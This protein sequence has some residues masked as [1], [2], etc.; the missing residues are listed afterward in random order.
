MITQAASSASSAQGWAGVA[1]SLVGLIGLLLQHG[2]KHA[3]AYFADRK[4]QRDLER[5]RLGLEQAKREAAEAK[6]EAAEAKKL[7]AEAEARAESAEERLRIMEPIV[8]SN[9]VRTASLEGAQE[10]MM[11]VLDSM[12]ERKL[13]VQPIRPAR[14]ARKRPRKTVLV[15]EDDPED[16]RVLRKLLTILGFAANHSPTVA[17]ALEKL[18]FYPH[19]IIL[20]LKMG[21]GDGLEIL[22]KIRQNEMPVRTIILTGTADPAREAEARALAPDFYLTKPANPDELL[23]ALAHEDV[24]DPLG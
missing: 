23:K 6:K 22:R 4:D 13:I 21:T 16:A 11:D 18:D 8:D 5:Q 20:D 9:T 14:P 10:G 19:C 15:V 12:A 17:D 3:P 2:F 7:A 24:P 1:V